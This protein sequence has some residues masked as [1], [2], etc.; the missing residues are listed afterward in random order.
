MV[1]HAGGRHLHGP[2]WLQLVGKQSH[3]YLLHFATLN[4]DAP[5]PRAREKDPRA[6][7]KSTQMLTKKK[8]KVQL[9][10]SAVL[11]CFAR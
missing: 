3:G 1:H 11:L 9:V 10:L 8:K 2:G 6:P 4:A 7:E 5:R